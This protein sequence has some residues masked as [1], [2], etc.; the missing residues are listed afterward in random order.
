MATASM[1]VN[2]LRQVQIG[3]F[4][5][6]S[7]RLRKK[8]RKAMFADADV[9]VGDKLVATACGICMKVG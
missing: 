7:C 1:T 6:V 8:G 3:D 4:L 2:F 9:W 5:T